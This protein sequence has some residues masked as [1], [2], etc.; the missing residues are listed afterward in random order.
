MKYEMII[1]DVDGTLWDACE[2]TMEAANIVADKYPGLRKV[3]LDDIN[4][5]MGLTADEIATRLYPDL[6]KTKAMQIIKEII[7]LSQKIINE[8]GGSFYEKAI[9]TIKYLST[10]YKLGIVTNNVDSYAKLLID[11]GNLSEYFADY[12]GALSYNISKGEAI[13]MMLERN[14]VTRACYIGD[15]K[16]DMV[17][18]SEAGVDFIHAKYGFGKDLINDVSIDNIGELKNM[19]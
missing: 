14:N 11:K 13:K 12:I 5:V 15:I 8:Q 4:Y 1:F 7:M 10:K 16:K 3:T 18:S 9:E 6:D 2:A 17:A 19:L